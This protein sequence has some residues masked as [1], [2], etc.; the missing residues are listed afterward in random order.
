MADA[1]RERLEALLREH[2]EDRSR[3][4]HPLDT[5]L[6]LVQRLREALTRHGRNEQ[7]RNVL[8]QVHALLDAWDAWAGPDHGFDDRFY[9]ICSCMDWLRE[10]LAAPADVPPLPEAWSD[11]GRDVDPECGD[12]VTYRRASSTDERIDDVTVWGPGPGYGPSVNVR[13]LVPPDEVHAVL[14]HHLARHGGGA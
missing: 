6:F 11:E 2:D 13:G 5:A 4:G 3:G 7:T 1:L 8:D 14:A 9:L 10:A 12:S